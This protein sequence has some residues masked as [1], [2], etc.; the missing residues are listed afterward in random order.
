MKDAAAKGQMQ[1]G[2]GLPQAKL[3]EELVREIRTRYAAKEKSQKQLAR[4]YKVGQ[5]TISW[6]VRGLTWKHVK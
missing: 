5:M 4:E 2:E 1:R 6:L 3:T